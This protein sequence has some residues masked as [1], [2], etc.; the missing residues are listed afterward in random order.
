[1]STS[2]IDYRYR[3]SNSELDYR[4][5]KED[6][7]VVEDR[8]EIVSSLVTLSETLCEIAQ[9]HVVSDIFRCS[10]MHW[11]ACILQTWLNGGKHFRKRWK[12]EKKLKPTVH[13]KLQLEMTSR[14]VLIII[15]IYIMQLSNTSP[16]P[17]SE[18]RF[19]MGG[20]I[21][22]SRIQMPPLTHVKTN[23]YKSK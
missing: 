12:G 13:V 18:R 10:L 15:Y 16:T 19:R 2:K 22:C 7:P 20:A 6:L 1:M 4:Q 17:P 14:Y 9:L 5:I 11:L 3:I 23:Q 8:E 21:D